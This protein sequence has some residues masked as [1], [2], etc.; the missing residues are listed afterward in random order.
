MID[1]TQAK[2]SDVPQ[3]AVYIRALRDVTTKTGSSTTRAQGIL[4]R[5]IPAAVLV[6][7]IAEL[8]E[9]TEDLTP[10]EPAPKT[11]ED[12]LSGR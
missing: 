7:L 1:L 12:V 4:F 3:L 5:A 6:E 2:S 8:E 10:T 9:P 11:V